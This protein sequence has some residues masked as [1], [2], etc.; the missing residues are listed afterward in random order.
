MGPEGSRCCIYKRPPPVSTLSHI[1]PVHTPHSTSWKPILILSSH[2]CLCLTSGLL[3]QFS[4]PKPCI[5]FLSPIHG[6]WPAH[7]I[8]LDLINWI[9]FGEKYRSLIPSLC[10]FVHYSVTSSLLGPNSLLNILL[11]NTLSRCSSLNVS[12]KVSHPYKSTDKIIVL[13][14]LIFIFLD[15]NLQDKRFC[16]EWLQVFRKSQ[17]ALNFMLNRI[18]IKVV[19]KYFKFYILSKEILSPLYC[20]RVLYSDLKTWP[21]T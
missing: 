17:P 5:H 13:Y 6:T 20:D 18:F 8:L 4:P 12:N 10:S 14:I 7:L 15:S 19:P 21:C 16:T 2:L 11:S 1:N 3:S 9:I